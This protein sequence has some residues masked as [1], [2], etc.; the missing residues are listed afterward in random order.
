MQLEFNLGARS[1]KHE[2]MIA[3]GRIHIVKNKARRFE[4][5]HEIGKQASSLIAHDVDLE[6]LPA[7]TDTNI[8]L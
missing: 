3:R 7:I 2:A 1:S 8:D 5:H 4:E 6:L